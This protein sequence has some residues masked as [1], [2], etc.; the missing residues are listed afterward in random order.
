[1]SEDV[2]RFLLLQAEDAARITKM[3]C[4]TTLAY[5]TLILVIK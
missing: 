2:P 4:G 1:M 5:W 3:Q